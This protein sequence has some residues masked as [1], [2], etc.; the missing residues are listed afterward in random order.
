MKPHPHRRRAALLVGAV[1]LAAHAC[2]GDESRSIP[3]PPPQAALDERMA[4]RIRTAADE[5]RADPAAPERWLALGMTYE[6]NELCALAIECYERAL[7][8]APSAKAWHRLACAQ[9]T[10]GDAAAAV[11]A[12]LHSIELEPGYAPSHWRLGTQLFDLGEFDAALRAFEEVTRLDPQHLGGPI[13]C[14]RVYLQRG[15]PAR[16][17]AALEPA[18]RARPEDRTLQRL[19]HT[20]YLQAG[21]GEDAAKIDLSPRGRVQSYGRDP[22]QREFLEH[23]ER[24]VMEKALELLQAGDAARAVELLE[25]FT[26]QAPDDL[27]ASAYLAQAYLQ[28]NRIDEALRVVSDGLEREPDN[29]HLL[30]ALARLQEASGQLDLALATLA[31]MLAIDANDVSSWRNKGRLE[32]TTGRREAALESLRRARALD[33]REPDVLVEIGGLELGLGRFDEAIRSFEEARREGVQRPEL[34]L[35][36]A[37]AYARAG[38]VAEAIELVSRTSG[39]GRAGEALLDELRGQDGGTPR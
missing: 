9:A 5:L 21:R 34:V 22:W 25:E 32:T 15:E 2:S 20:A 36:L 6:A 1:V 27:N 39:L 13:G 11:A 26:A 16:A 4:A 35:G 17:I 10:A 30:R 7:E 24:P 29:L 8:V 3:L 12:M 31:R 18:M 37:R 38:R 28:A 33:R 19:L 14:A 23:W